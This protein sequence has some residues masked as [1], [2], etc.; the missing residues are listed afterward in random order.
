MTYT[1]TT[2]SKH[3]S[4]YRPVRDIA[5]DI[6]AD[7]KVAKQSGDLPTDLDLSITTRTFAGGQSIDIVIRGHEDEWQEEGPTASDPWPRVRLTDA[8]RDLV[9]KVEV[10]ANAY[11]KTTRDPHTDYY[12]TCY[13]ASVEVEQTSQRVWRERE[14][15]ARKAKRDAAK[16]GR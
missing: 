15:A 7:V 14:A 8:A 11:N 16:A 10:I 13:Y 6:R 12:D 5:R 4:D 9:R 1:T 2:G 3:S